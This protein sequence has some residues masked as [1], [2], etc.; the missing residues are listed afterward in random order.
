MRSRSVARAPFG[1]VSRSLSFADVRTS[2]S[3]PRHRRPAERRQVDAVQPPHAQPR[4]DRADLPGLTRDRHYGE[5]RVGGKPYHRHRHRRLRAGRAR[6]HHASRWR[7]RREQ[8][9]AEADAVVFVVDGRAGPDAAGPRDRRAAAQDRRARSGSSSTR[10]KACSRR[11]SRPNSTSSALG[12]PLRDFGRARRGRARAAWTWCSPTSRRD[13]ADEDAARAS[14]PRIA[15]VGRP[16]V[17]KSTL[18]NAL[19]GEER[20]I[21]FDQPGTTRDPIEVDFERGGRRYTLIDTAGVRRRGNVT[22]AIEKF[23]V[24]KTL[25]AIE[26]A[27]VVDPGA[28][29]ARAD[30][31]AGRAYRRLHPRARPRAGGGGQQMGRLAAEQRESA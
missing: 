15:I 11:P 30:R 9:I 19:L 26:D 7:G 31:R 14:H 21:A 27:N 29:R 3:N 10:P 28:R 20:V 8:A 22:D 23:S 25:Q 1:A 4:R 18:V 24:V 17:G 13:E 12:E 16:N 6:G 5:G 2:D